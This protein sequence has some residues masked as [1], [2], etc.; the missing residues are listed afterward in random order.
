[1]ASNPGILWQP[2]KLQHRLQET[3]LG[4][5]YWSKKMEQYRVTRAELGIKLM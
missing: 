4:K 5:A 2:Q 1:M 3:H